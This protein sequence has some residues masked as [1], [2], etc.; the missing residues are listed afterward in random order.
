MIVLKK[1]VNP[2]G[3][4]T[5]L[6]LALVV[7]DGVYASRGQSVMRVTSLRD[8][9]HG[10]TSLHYDGAA[11]DLGTKEYGPP[12]DFQDLRAVWLRGLVR[13]IRSGLGHN[14]AYDVLFEG[15]GL[16]HEHIHIEWQPKSA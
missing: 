5:E 11:G 12:S 13:E 3:I 10:K 6:L 9:K 14:A 1:G 2:H 15:A 7:A 16:A 4:R 8:S